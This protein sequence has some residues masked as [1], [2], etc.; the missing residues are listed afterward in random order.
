L[1]TRVLDVF[2]SDGFVKHFE[3]RGQRG[4]YTALSHSWGKSPR[5]TARRSNIEDLK[6][7]IALSSLPRT[8]KDAIQITQRLQ[9]RYIW[10]DCLCVIQDDPLDWEKEA[11]AMGELYRNS[12]ITIAAAS[13]IDSNTGCFPQGKDAPYL[14]SASQSLEWL[15]GSCSATPQKTV[16]GSFGQNFDPLEDEP[17]STRG[18]TL[19]ERLL[20]S[21]IIHYAKDQMYY[22]CD[23]AV[24]SEDGLRVLI[25]TQLL[26]FEQHGVGEN[27]ASF[28]EG[29]LPVDKTKRWDG[30]WLGMVQNYSLRKLT[31]DQ[32][33]LPALS[34]LARMLAEETGDRY[35][36]GLWASH[37]PEDLFWRGKALGEVTKPKQYR[38]PSWSWAS[39]DAP[40]RFLPLT[41]KNLVASVVSCS[42]TPTHTD[43]YGRV[44]AGRLVI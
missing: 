10:I 22:Q 29:H 38:A 32:D 15:P 16:I 43:E 5:L 33:K 4:R 3:S 35:F 18:W 11:Q 12:Y 17:L 13:S 27:S 6:C 44:K 39:L 31:V 9:I 23:C 2:A 25:Q 19:Q 34:G 24:K 26:P 40:I 36:A 42:T 14:S 41:Y 8:F 7:G 30:G 21:R 37:L 28:I 20:P 1:P